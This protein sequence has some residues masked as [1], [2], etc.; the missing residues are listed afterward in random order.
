MVKAVQFYS[1]GCRLEGDLY[2]PDDLAGDQKRPG[3]VICCG[4]TGVKDMWVNEMA[5]RFAGAGY[6]A[7]TFNYKGWGKSEG[8]PLRLA[9]FGRVEDTQAA[10]TFLELQPEVDRDRIALYGISYGGSTAVYTAAIDPRAKAVVSVTGVGDGGRWMR[11]VRR[12]W[13]YRELLERSIRDRERQVMSG[14]SEMADR[15]EV[16]MQD[17]KSQE[18]GARVRAGV[19]SAAMQAPLE[20]IH[21]TLGFNPEWVVDRISPRASLFITSDLDELVLP[22]E[23]EALYA[24]AGEPKKLVVLRGF[25]HYEVFLPPALDQVMDETFDW[26]SEHV[27]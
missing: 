21:E 1:G 6:V 26:L 11:H 25:S 22:E 3:V 13:E 27:T 4:Y 7:L 8:P 24:W 15:S 20:F 12:P 19:P 18:V 14:Q 10:L 9:P 16:L 17:P 23:S 2:L 5:R